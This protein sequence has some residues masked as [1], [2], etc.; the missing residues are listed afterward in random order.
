MYTLNTYAIICKNLSLKY[1]RKWKF[2]NFTFLLC[3]YVPVDLEHSEALAEM[4]VK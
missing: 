3:L 2:A 1:R 4:G